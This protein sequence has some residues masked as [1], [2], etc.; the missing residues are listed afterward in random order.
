MVSSFLPPRHH[1][2]AHAGLRLVQPIADMSD[3]PTRLDHLGPS[4]EKLMKIGG[5]PGVSIG[6]LYGDKPAYVAQYGVRNVEAA[7]PI[8]HETVFTAGSLTKALTAAAMGIIIDEGQATWD[9]LVKDVLPSFKS[10]DETLQNHATLTDILS[11]RTGMSWADNL[12][13][14]TASNVLISSE[15]AMKYINN[16]TLLLPFRAQFAYSNLCYELAGHVIEAL[17]GQSYFDFV[18]TRIFDPLGMSRTFLKTPPASIDN[19]ASCYNTLDDL[20]AVPIPCAKTGDDWFG[21]PTGGL[22]SCVRDL[23]KLYRAFLT[24]YNDQFSSGKSSTEGSPLKQVTHLMSA[25]IPMDQPSRNEASYA[26]GWGRVQLLGKMGQIGI[27]P[28]LLPNEMPTIAKGVPG[29]LVIFHQG[30]LP[31]TLTIAILV[32]DKD[33]AIVVLTNSLALNDVPDWIGQLI[34]EE[35]L[36]VPPSERVDFIKSAEA[37]VPENLR[38]Y[39]ELIKELKDTRKN[40]TV[41][42]DLEEY[43]GTYWDDI[44]TFKIV[45]TLEQGKLHWAFQGLD[46]EK[47]ELNHYEDDTFLWLAPRNE[48]SRRGRWVGSDQGPD[49]W[50]AKFKAA[51]DAKVDKLYWSHDQGVPP[52]EYTKE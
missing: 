20:S 39:P 8:D 18:Q 51:S 43:V 35:V 28:G 26:L 24:S 1:H 23:L 46:S 6:V 13:I 40:D 10:R 22:R 9:T 27:N 36:K 31:G 17:S 12:W 14:G 11:H 52:V 5:T 4:I 25:K 48:L 45:V 7:L 3:L 50:K 37:S 21:G 47:F 49:F 16:Q 38:W 15:D 42:R 33:V 2:S 19:R 32:P 34:L 44:R 41:A 30:S 29:Q